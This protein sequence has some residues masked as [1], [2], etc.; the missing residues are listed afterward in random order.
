MASGKPRS[1]K[2]NSSSS[3]SSYLSTITLL[4]FIALCVLGVWVLT[5]SSVVPQ[6]SIRTSNSFS[7]LNTNSHF[8][9]KSS[10]SH[11]DPPAFDDTP[12]DL[13]DDALKGDA[14]QD[15]KSDE[16]KQSIERT[17]EV[18]TKPL[19]PK[20]ETEQISNANTNE[21]EPEK[22]GSSSSTEENSQNQE[23]ES[24]EEEQKQENQGTNTGDDNSN[25]NQQMEK[26]NTDTEQ[27]TTTQQTKDEESNVNN[28]ELQSHE[29]QIQQDPEVEK[30]NPNQNQQ[31]PEVESHENPNQTQQDPEI[32]SKENPQQTQSDSGEENTS[33]K[34]IMLLAE[35]NQQHT[36][37][38]SSNDDTQQQNSQPE[39]QEVTSE[40][41]HHQQQ[42]QQQQQQEQEQTQQESSN[43]E[44]QQSQTNEDQQSQQSTEGNTEVENQESQKSTENE[45]NTSNQEETHQEISNSSEEKSSESNSGDSFPAGAHAGIPKE[46]KESNRAWSTQADQSENQKE[47][48]KDGS[49]SDGNKDGTIYGYTWEL[50]NV[51]SGA[52]YIPCL[53]NEKA[54]KLL[55]YTGHF[56][57]RERHCPEDPPTC[58]VPLPPGYKKPIEW[59]KSRDKIWY[60]NVPH[61]K[62]AV[63]KGHQNWVKVTGEFLTFPGGGTQFIHGALHYID[64]IQQSVPNIAWGKRTRVV[65]DVGCGVASFGGYLFERDVLAMSFAPKDEHEA[66]VQ[67]AL[68]RGIPAIS[69]VMGSQRLPFPSRVFDL[70]HCARCRVPWHAEGGRLLL[71]L[72]RVLRPG[73][74]FVWSA[75]PVYQKLPEDV[76]IW[77]EMSKLTI[78][79][80]WE[81][82]TIKK[83]KLNSI[84]AAVYRKP[85]S[86]DCYEQRKHN[87][88]PMCKNDDDPNAAWYVPLQACIHRVP[89]D[90]VERGAQ[91]PEEW[92]ARVHKPP[93]WLNSSQKGIY[94]KPAPE[95]FASDYEHWK[96][97]VT[98]SYMTGLGISW[99]NVRNVMDMRAVY[100][101]FAAA[102]KD[103]KVWVMNVVNV[104][105]PDTLPIIYERGLF[106]MYH[107]W[108][109][110]FSTYPRTYDL[111]HADHL[112]SRLKKRCKL[113]PVIAEI[114]RIVRPGGKLI[115]RDESSVVGEIENMLKSLHWEIHLTF[116]KDQEG[117]LSAQKSD[118]RPNSNS[119]SS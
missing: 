58:L 17:N 71:E 33:Q 97:V 32:E 85:I 113:V 15:T 65:L 38:E 73:G 42:Q 93:Y 77:K 56:E 12:G 18:L 36:Q 92:P 110:S 2:R 5:S 10:V 22:E 74:Y 27:E 66:Q 52:D 115:V 45:N 48:R 100:G 89:T 51:T 8:S 61:T 23:K 37:Q 106:G 59:P 63:V 20:L 31:D 57:H 119:A 116:S 50:C 88:P 95:D 35:D 29:E 82:F 16:L 1:G 43:D 81:L 111:L 55:H 68:E 103:I 80:C 90:E 6:Q 114:D 67:F 47:R 84:G 78:S 69:A 107:D 4:V 7:S 53:D 87:S 101:G 26:S 94:G 79:M 64:F 72:N 28:Q 21:D 9:A 19:E 117:I 118:W 96:R 86:N 75:T 105:S 40:D 25:E 70:V 54:I 14:D 41:H 44:T 108:C 34:P 13:P 76:E 62:L 49:S 104:D 24:A 91:W 83:D 60:H 3:S 46:S 39:I 109:E 112:F 30:E 11:K 102:L 98:K 99:S